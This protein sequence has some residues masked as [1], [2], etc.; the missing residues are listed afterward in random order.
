[1]NNL[2]KYLVDNNQALFN[3]VNDILELEALNC[4]QK[5]SDSQLLYRFQLRAKVDK[6]LILEEI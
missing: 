1:M 6:F 3:K 4:I 5:G 2:F